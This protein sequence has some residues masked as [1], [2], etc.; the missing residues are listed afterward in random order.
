MCRLLGELAECGSTAG[1]LFQYLGCSEQDGDVDQQVDH[2]LERKRLVGKRTCIG[3]QI[4]YC[5][6]GDEEQAT[7]TNA[8]KE[9]PLGRMI[10]FPDTQKQKESYA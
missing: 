5:R 9:K 1:L 7:E 10:G 4:L 3:K 2:I 6:E 8:S